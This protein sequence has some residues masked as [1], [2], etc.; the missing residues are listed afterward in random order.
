MYNDED[1]ERM[2]HDFVYWW[3][4]TFPENGF[5]S[6]YN[7]YTWD[8]GSSKGDYTA[9]VNVLETDIPILEILDE[10][11]LM[12][13]ANYCRIALPMKSYIVSTLVNK[14]GSISLRWKGFIYV[15]DRERFKSEL[16]VTLCDPI[17]RTINFS[18][19]RIVINLQ[20]TKSCL[21]ELKEKEEFY[22]R[23]VGQS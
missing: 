7:S 12:L 21:K 16:C 2:A 11:E 6:Q 3:N 19:Q 14:N 18:S 8:V 15:V 10:D 23:C 9:K 20:I 13:V 4:K 17:I 22:R 5:P 1:F